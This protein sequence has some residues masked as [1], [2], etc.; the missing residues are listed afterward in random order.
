[1]L[2]RKIIGID[3]GT[4]EVKI[5][6]KGAGVVL[7]EKNVVAI[8]NRKKVIASGNF[9][10]DMLGKSPE[11]IEVS[12]PI[13][14]GVIADVGKMQMLL[15]TFIEKAFNGKKIKNA[16]YLVAVPTDI[17]EVEKRAFCDVIQRSNAKVRNIF[18][19]DKPVSAALGMEIDVTGTRGVLTVDIG[20]DTTEIAII[21]L[22]GIVLSKLIPVGGY[23]FDSLIQ[24]AIRKKYNLIVG[25]KTAE[26]VKISL[27]SAVEPGE[28]VIRV[29]GRDVL[30]GL[31]SEA[32][33]ST[34]MIYE[35]INE[36]LTS[37]LSAIRVILERTPPE[38]SADIIR[39]GIYVTGGSAMIKNLKEC[40]EAETNL[41]V[42][43]ADDAEYSVINGV[44]K[45]S[46]DYK[47]LKQ[48]AH[49]V[50]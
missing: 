2:G 9:A 30:S 13:Q 4:S 40:I 50:R 20:A 12:M 3:F 37:V 15:S 38:I 6:R 8:K 21:S 7:K 33:V 1:M 26:N 25:D 28:D 42:N 19:V 41:K 16:D 39:S 31:P 14:N 27:A 34:E 47:L 43:I 35:A 24:S 29:F 10:Y 48:V 23:K 22:G 18:M 45:I 32:M 46:E 36:Q 11:E 44:G 5:Y 17:T 49:A